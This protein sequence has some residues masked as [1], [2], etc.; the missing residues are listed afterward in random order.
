MK[1]F[2]IAVPLLLLTCG[3]SQAR[4]VSS[5]EL[6]VY[7]TDPL[8]HT[9]YLGTD[10]RFHHFTTQNGKAGSHVRVRRDDARIQPEPF[11]L[12]SGRDAF[13]RSANEKEIELI[14]LRAN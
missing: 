6:P 2:C 11:A 13:V 9:I 4:V 8:M 5:R 7:G 3:C 10:D 12:N 14:V 1:R